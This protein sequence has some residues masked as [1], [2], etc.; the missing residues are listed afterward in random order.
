M[1]RIR[2]TDVLIAGVVLILV[3]ACTLSAAST[4]PRAAAPMASPASATPAA[5]DAARHA[6]P[7]PAATSTPPPS[8]AMR[9][10]FDLPPYADLVK[11]FDYDTAEPLGATVTWTEE[12][13]GAT[14]ER[15]TY[16]VNGQDVPAIL[17][18]PPGGGPFPAILY[19][20][21]SSLAPAFWL[22]DMLAFAREGYAGLAVQ[23]P[24]DEVPGAIETPEDAATES[25]AIEEY[26]VRLRRALDL[27]AAMPKV[28]ATRL[29]Y[30]GHSFG[31]WAGSILSG[32]D[33]RIRAYALMESGGYISDLVERQKTRNDTLHTLSPEWLSVTQP[34]IAVLNPVNY[35]G[36]SD[37]AFLVEAAEDGTDLATA[38]K[39]ALYDALPEPKQISW[40]AG[41]HA[42]GCLSR[43]P[44]DLPAFVDHRTWLKE[45]V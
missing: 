36:H 5:T 30:V 20:H 18:I 32:V 8:P 9:T 4:A 44:A 31:G 28:D 38:N 1:S 26:V 22:D 37:A 17:V 42:L 43:C 33:A 35:V 19:G 21:G 2:W 34:A 24:L 3:A 6:P 25:A 39:Q 16:R 7:T 13:D 12:T 41:G 15:L 11:L 45:H 27:L 29:G 40:Y 23:A 10:E 14:V